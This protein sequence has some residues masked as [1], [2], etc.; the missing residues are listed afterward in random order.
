MFTLVYSQHSLNLNSLDLS[1]LKLISNLRKYT[2]PSW[3]KEV[4][5]WSPWLWHWTEALHIRKIDAVSQLELYCCITGYY[6]HMTLYKNNTAFSSYCCRCRELRIN[7]QSH[8]ALYWYWHYAVY[9]FLC[10]F[11]SVIYR[12]NLICGYGQ[13]PFIGQMGTFLVAIKCWS[14]S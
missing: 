6:H 1:A 9:L 2:K 4:C 10:S 7:Y 11:C 13:K 12:S 14:Y 3:I 8:F 5:T